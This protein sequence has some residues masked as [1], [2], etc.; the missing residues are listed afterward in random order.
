MHH[1]HCRPHARTRICRLVLLGGRGGGGGGEAR[2]LLRVGERQLRLGGRGGGGGVNRTA[3]QGLK[4][5]N[6]EDGSGG[7]GCLGHGAWKRVWRRCV[8]RVCCLQVGMAPRAM[9]VSG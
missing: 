8:A 3:V 6:G 4:A 2:L 9:R 1:T 7:L 5:E